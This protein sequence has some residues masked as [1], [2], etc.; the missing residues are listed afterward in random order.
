[1]VDDET[2][3][4][5]ARQAS[6]WHQTK[7]EWLLWFVA[8]FGA[9]LALVG[10]TVAISTHYAQQNT[11]ACINQNLGARNAPNVADR[12]VTDKTFA[13]FAKALATPGPTSLPVILAALAQYQIQRAQDDETR[14]KTPLGKC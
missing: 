4:R 10:T 3:T 6:P 9:I 5:I 12:M 14:A 8:A 13:Q 2:V 1:M 11:A 7:R